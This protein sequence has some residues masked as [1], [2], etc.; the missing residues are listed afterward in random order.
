MHRLC[1]PLCVWRGVVAGR[2][3]GLTRGSYRFT[4]LFLAV[5]NQYCWDTDNISIIDNRCFRKLLPDS[6]DTKP[7]LGCLSGR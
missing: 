1:E 5:V 4:Y 2:C 6:I 3:F 7:I